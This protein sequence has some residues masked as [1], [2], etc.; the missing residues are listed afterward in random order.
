MISFLKRGKDTSDATATAGDILSPKTAYVD[1][2]KITG[3][4]SNNIINTLNNISL[5]QLQ[6]TSNP[7]YF[8]MNNDYIVHLDFT[9]HNVI[10]SD[11]TGIKLDELNIVG[12]NKSDFVNIALGIIENNTCYGLINSSSTQA[13]VFKIQD[14]KFVS[15][16]TLTLSNNEKI[17][18][19]TASRNHSQVFGCVYRKSYVYNTAIVKVFSIDENLDILSSQEQQTDGAFVQYGYFTN[20]DNYFINARSHNTSEK[21][22]RIDLYKVSLNEN[23]VTALNS[24]TV[25]NYQVFYNDD[26]TLYINN[27]VLYSIS[28]TLNY[29]QI[30]PVSYQGSPLI[31]ANNYLYTY[32]SNKIYLYQ[33]SNSGIELKFTFNLSYSV[34]D[35]YVRW[36]PNNYI[37]FYYGSYMDF[38]KLNFSDVL[39]TMTAKGA[40]LYNPYDANASAGD[41]L[42]NKIAY[43]ANGKV[44]GSMLN[45]GSISITPSAS[46]QTKSAGYYSNIIVE[47]VTSSIDSNIIPENIKSGVTILGVTGTYTGEM[48]EV[49]EEG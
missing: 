26:M 42:Q 15:K 43:G 37:G 31:I 38:T 22:E 41:M 1:G 16:K 48:S 5:E 27:N 13:V 45:N 39:S 4:I 12:L 3:T 20:N 21:F 18:N 7:A 49:V 6:G 47:G 24:I 32:S 36:N 28:S 46:A 35:S 40:T 30:M 19:I 23:I 2:E 11:L 10:L 8:A 34:K 25:P 9:N 44:K 17:I 14:E 29:T 33:V